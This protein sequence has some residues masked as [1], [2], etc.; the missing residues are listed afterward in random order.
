ML[1]ENSQGASPAPT[2][3]V[4]APSLFRGAHA[5]Q[6]GTEEEGGGKGQSVQCY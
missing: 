3:T 5:C 6:R 2:F 4:G 1:K